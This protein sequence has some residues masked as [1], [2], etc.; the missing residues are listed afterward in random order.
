MNIF[1]GGFKHKRV[2]SDFDYLVDVAKIRLI[3][4]GIRRSEA[5]RLIDK[6]IKKGKYYLLKFFLSTDGSEDEGVSAL[7]R[8]RTLEMLREGMERVGGVIATVGSGGLLL[9]T[10]CKFTAILPFMRAVEGTRTELQYTKDRKLCV[11]LG[12]I[13][14]LIGLRVKHITIVS[15]VYNKE[16]IDAITDILSNCGFQIKEIDCIYR[17]KENDISVDST[18]PI[19]A[20][21]DI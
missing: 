9:S 1:N 8:D 13:T 4:R 10:V 17:K 12:M 2:K 19:N 18:T 15:A 11:P 16:S 5:T 6:E 20:L 7:F 3:N 21:F 14:K